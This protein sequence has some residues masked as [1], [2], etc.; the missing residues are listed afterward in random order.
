MTELL[1]TSAPGNI[2]GIGHNGPPSEIDSQEFWHALI[3][4]RVAAA[5][6]DVTPRSMQKWR[7]TGEGPPFIEI[8]SR[9]KKYTRH[10]CWL[11]YVARLRSSTND[12]GPE[13]PAA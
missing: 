5:F 8:S 4:E 1:Y 3:D 6:L 12:P 10:R 9:C 13:A 2:P 7:Q 11:W